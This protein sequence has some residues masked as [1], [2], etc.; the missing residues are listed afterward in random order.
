MS[1]Q[2]MMFAMTT[3]PTIRCAVTNGKIMSGAVCGYGTGIESWVDQKD[4][5][6]GQFQ[7]GGAGRIK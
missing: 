6:R 4:S 2:S 5:E 1:D 3:R 7:F